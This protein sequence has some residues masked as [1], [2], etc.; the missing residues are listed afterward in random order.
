MCG[1]A[2]IVGT[3]GVNQRIYDALT[4]LQH[5][6]QDAAGIATVPEGE[7]FMRKGQGLVRDVFQQHHMLELKG[8]IGMGHVRYPTAGCDNA[9][10]A[11]PFYRERAVRHLPRAQRQSHQRARARR[12]SRARRPPPPEHQFRLRSAAQR[13]GVRAAASGHA[14]RHASRHL[15]RGERGISPLPRRLRGGGHGHRP[16]TA[17]HSAIR[18]GIR[19]LVLGQRETPQGRRVDAGLRERGA[20]HAR[21]QARARC[22]AG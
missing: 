3:S 8:N 14:A 19:P 10:E 7:L 20:R 1:I 12:S 5:R 21:F 11:Q 18:N 13:A 15:R 6:G 4:V 16:R 2:G 17:R 22:R 9:A